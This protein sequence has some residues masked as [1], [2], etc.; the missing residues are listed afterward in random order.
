VAALRNGLTNITNGLENPSHAITKLLC[1]MKEFHLRL[2]RNL[3]RRT[4]VCCIL[5][6]P[7]GESKAFN[8]LQNIYIK[9]IMP[10]SF[11]GIL[12]PLYLYFNFI[13][14]IF[15]AKPELYEMIKNTTESAHWPLQA[16][17]AGWLSTI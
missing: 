9:S 8:L 12:F 7:T 4:I 16:G 1:L 15:A 5:L 11:H 17:Y 3:S 13:L 14:V 2:D 10:P 6:C